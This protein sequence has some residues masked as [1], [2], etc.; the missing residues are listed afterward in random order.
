MESFR[1]LLFFI[2]LSLLSLSAG[3]QE[4]DRTASTLYLGAGPYIQDQPY[5]GAG[6]L[7]LPTPVVFFDNR[8]LYARWARFGIYLYG[9]ENWG[10]SITAQPVPLQYEAS[11]SDVLSGMK[12]RDSSWEAG[13][14]LGGEND[15]G[16]AELALFRDILGRS[17]GTKLRL[18]LGK[19]WKKGRWTLVPSL[20]A[21]GLS[22]D[23]NDYYYGV[24]PSE[25][26]PGRP[27][28]ETGSGLNLA[29]QSYLMYDL[30]PNWHLLGNLRIDHLSSE[31]SDS[32]IVDR[33]WYWSGMVSVLY[34]F[35]VG[36]N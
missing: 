22:S 34:S 7:V 30:T 3:A 23:Y 25:A 6:S 31:A 29:A 18:E 24:R 2:L 11:D 9:R 5:E 10:L 17:G 14:A 15:L 4:K 21:I 36:G 20:L 13:F 12:D 19:R 32:P 26:R 8:R 16:F 1:S 33:S 27:A 35:P 28:Y